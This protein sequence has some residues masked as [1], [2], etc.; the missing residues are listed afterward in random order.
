M[1]KPFGLALHSVAGDDQGTGGVRALKPLIVVRSESGEESDV[2]EGVQCLY[3]MYMATMDIGSGFICMEE[4]LAIHALAVACG[5]QNIEE[6]EKYV[7]EKILNHKEQ[8]WRK[9][10]PKA[11]G[12]EAK[13]ARE[14][15][16]PG[17]PDPPQS[18]NA[19]ESQPTNG[20]TEERQQQG[21]SK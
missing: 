14:L 9:L 4:A 17:I 2:T 18:A 10:N 19:V 8:E 13:A 15:G 7:A 3:D 21:K 6:I 5:F 12:T 11:T 1:N 16:F 20:R